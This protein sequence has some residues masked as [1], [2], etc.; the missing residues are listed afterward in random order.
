MKTILQIL[1]FVL[2]MSID[3]CRPK[4][5]K[6]QTDQIQIQQRSGLLGNNI[7]EFVQDKKHKIF[8]TDPI[9]D[10]INYKRV[11]DN[12]YKDDNEKYYILNVCFRPVSDDTLLYL[13]Y[14]RDETD[15]LDI[16]SYRQI[17]SGYFVNK[18]RVFYW[19]GNSDGDYPIEVIGADPKTFIPFDS[20]AGG[21]DRQFVY[22]GSPPKDFNVINGADP[23]SIKVLN[24]KRGC[25]NCGN[26]YFK[27]KKAVYYGCKK[28]IGADSKTFKLLNQHNFD[29]EDKNGKYFEG[30]IVK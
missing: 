9:D 25:W 22:Y 2:F 1:I 4:Q 5:I 14:F 11:I 3:S 8:F 23:K 27:D 19:W 30:L 29:A 26:C 15:F 13:E 17:K 24:P 10:T 12:I 6:R 28:I 18:G 16:K 21:T 20:V 7:I